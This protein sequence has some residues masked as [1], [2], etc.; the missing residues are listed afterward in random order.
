M[1]I[2]QLAFI[3]DLIIEEDL[4]KCNFNI[5]FIKIG[6]F[7]K[8]IELDNYEKVELQLYQYFIGKLIYFVFNIR[9]DIMFVVGQLSKYYANPRKNYIRVTK[10][11][12]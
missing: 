11:V 6:S 4:T 2:N 3:K 12:V 10:R 1:E 8:I 5:I 7:I 9:P